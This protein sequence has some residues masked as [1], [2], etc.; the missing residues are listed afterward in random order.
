LAIVKTPTPAFEKFMGMSRLLEDAPLQ[1]RIVP[2]NA[3]GGSAT[4]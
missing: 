1:P 4:F 2:H 3:G